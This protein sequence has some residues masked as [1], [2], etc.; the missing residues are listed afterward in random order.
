[1]Q[2][3]LAV[4][5]KNTADIFMTNR[6][7]CQLGGLLLTGPLKSVNIRLKSQLILDRVRKV[8]CVVYVALSFCGVLLRGINALGGHLKSF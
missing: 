3:N 2:I 6:G 5:M 8:M 7:L 1:M 4:L